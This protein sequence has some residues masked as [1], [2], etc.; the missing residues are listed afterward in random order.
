LQSWYDGCPIA[1]TT[2]F[3][4]KE[5]GE[6]WNKQ[7]KQNNFKRNY[8]CYFRDKQIKKNRPS[9]LM[10]CV[11]KA[12]TC[13]PKVHGSNPRWDRKT[14]LRKKIIYKLPMYFFPDKYK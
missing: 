12:W 13:I 11:V 1:M 5:K 2:F 3:G 4:V 6:N 14:N 9:Q 8:A 7:T 10:V